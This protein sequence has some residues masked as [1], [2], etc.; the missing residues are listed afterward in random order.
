MKQFLLSFLLIS[1][2][3]HAQITEFA[4]IGAYWK[5]SWAS[6]SGG[7]ELI[8]KVV[9]DTVANGK[10]FRKMYDEQFTYYPFPPYYGAHTY[11]TWFL[12]IR[13][14]S[15]FKGLSQDVFFCSLKMQLNDTIQFRA[16]GNYS[17]YAVA[18]S[19]GRIDLDGA[20]RRVVFVSKYC[21]NTQTGALKKSYYRSRI[22]DT[23]GL[24]QGLFWDEPD[25]GFLD[26]SIYSLNCYKAGSFQYPTNVNCAP[27]VAT[28]DLTDA[29]ISI[30]PNPVNT[31]LTINFSSELRLNNIEL[32]NYL[33]QKIETKKGEDLRKIS[34]S[35]LPNG[36]YF[37]RLL[38][39]NQSV[40]KKI[41]I[42]H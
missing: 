21:K 7:G 1:T 36:A 19:V 14:D 3:I 4:P 16:F 41:M 40:T 5:H 2:S 35:N 11:G 24:L 26:F 31:D 39:D 23:L 37:V 8:T 38:F 33:G 13:N 12:S 25:C 17:R 6:V 42:Q 18:D 20:N 27:T 10:K 30:F 34:V 15:I 29:Q 28:N 9:G 32:I 22:V